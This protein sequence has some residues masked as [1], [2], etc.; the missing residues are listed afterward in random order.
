MHTVI[1]R[2]PTNAEKMTD[3]K[4]WK[5]HFSNSLNA[6][7]WAREQDAQLDNERGNRW[8]REYLQDN[9]LIGLAFIGNW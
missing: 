9:E 8:P 7:Y 4:Q 6:L 3:W 1:V 2:Y 5:K